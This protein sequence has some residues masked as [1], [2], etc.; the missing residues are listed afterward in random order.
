M[1]IFDFLFHFCRR[2]NIVGDV[3]SIISLTPG[4][5]NNCFLEN[6]YLNVRT[7]KRTVL[8]F[9]INE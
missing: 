2:K 8:V 1:I 6:V 9:L 5:R 7:H 4:R 3:L